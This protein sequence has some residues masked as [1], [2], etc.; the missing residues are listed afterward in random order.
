M[1]DGIG[2]GSKVKDTLFKLDVLFRAWAFPIGVNPLV[3]C[4]L[5]TPTLAFY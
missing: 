1:S 2:P 5:Q 4:D 3:S